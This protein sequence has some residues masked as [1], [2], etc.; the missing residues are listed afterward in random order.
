MTLGPILGVLFDGFAYG[1]LLFLLSV[2]LS[3]TLG[4]MSFVNLAHRAFAMLGG[5]VTVT[6]MN[7]Y[8]WPFFWRRCR[9]RGRIVFEGDS[10]ALVGDPERL[11]VHLGVTERKKPNVSTH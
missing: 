1:M 7:V 4:M 2:G 9:Y 5:Y 10:A 3:M 8:A 11:E 6:L